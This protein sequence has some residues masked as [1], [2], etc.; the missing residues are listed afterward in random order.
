M[1]PVAATRRT[2]PSQ[3][4]LQACS[5]RMSPSPSKNSFKNVFARHDVMYK[6]DLFGNKIRQIDNAGNIAAGL[7]QGGDNP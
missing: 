6:L 3:P 7:L 4:S 5:K 2:I 1:G